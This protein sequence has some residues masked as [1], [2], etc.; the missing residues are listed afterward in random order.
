MNILKILTFIIVTIFFVLLLNKG[1]R[2]EEVVTCE[3]LKNYSLEF[4]GFY[5]TG[6]Q[7][8]MCDQ[9]GI[10]IDAPVHY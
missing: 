9:N 1:V 6:A 10:M 5:L 3:K 7:K 4:D 2:L 8:E